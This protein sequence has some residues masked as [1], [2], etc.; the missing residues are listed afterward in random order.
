MSFD[1]IIK[2]LVTITL[3]EMMLVVGLRAELAEILDTLK[4]WKMV[5]R[6]AVA[7]Y[8]IVPGITAALLM[9][10]DVSPMVA[11]G[12]VIVAVCPGAPY[13]PPFA[14]IA[15]ADVAASVGLMVILAGSSA[16]ISPILL[17]GVLPW[18]A[19]SEAPRLDVTGV[20]L[21]LLITQLL[22]LLIGLLVK[23]R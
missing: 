20:L 5:A 17:N 16:V 2:I 9:L 10:F 21:V 14:A 12:L 19:G 22:P 23:G 11:I 1:E 15:R 18:V 4:N 6:A 8:L 3:F 13:G 7:N